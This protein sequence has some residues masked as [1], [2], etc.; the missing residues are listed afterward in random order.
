MKIWPALALI[1]AFTFPCVAMASDKPGKDSPGE[2]PK[3]EEQEESYK[4]TIRWT[5]ASEVDNFGYDVYRAA[6]EEGPFE[7]LNETPIEGAGTSDVPQSYVYVDDTIDPDQE[8]FYYVESISMSG[9]RARFTPV[10]RV[11]PK[12]KS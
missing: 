9:E 8:Y 7:C 11:P 4:N 1:A 10:Y 2:T 5:T 3:K 12:R 6:N